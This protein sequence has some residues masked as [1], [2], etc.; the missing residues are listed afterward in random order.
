MNPLD[1]PPEAHTDAHRRAPGTALS[2]N[3]NKVALLRNT[4]H[5]GIPSVV[6]ASTLALEAGAQGI[7][8]H[9]R[10]DERHIRAHDVHDL[11]ALLKDWPQAEYNI[12]GNP[13]HNLMD[14]VRA[15]KPQQATFVP[16]SAGQFTS[17]HGWDLAADGDRLRP[18]ID[19]CACA[20]RAR[21]PV[22]GPAAR[23]DGRWR[24]R[25]APTAS[26]STPSPTPRPWPR[27][28]PTQLAA[29]RRRRA[30]GAGGRP[31]VNAGHDLN[32]DNL[33][34]FLR[35]VPGVLEVSIGHALIADALELGLPETVRDYLRCIRAAAVSVISASAPTSATCGACAPRSSGAASVSPRRVL[36]PSRTGRSSGPAARVPRCA[37][38]PTWPRASRPR[39]PSPRP[40]AWACACR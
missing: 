34:D 14:F 3:V 28:R 11:A 4:R 26:S 21:Q 38:W 37:A 30:R 12:E 39:R 6:R 13:F 33:A 10:P 36:G 5:L 18:L 24:A 7:T 16:D 29:L 1:P 40:S 31:G 17:D 9:P 23:G 2:V 8:V 22:H 15:L 20:G 19:E 25:S 27:G 32:R 35:A